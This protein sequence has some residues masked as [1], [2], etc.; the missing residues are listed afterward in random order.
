MPR[1]LPQR[2]VPEPIDPSTR[3][4]V[5]SLVHRLADEHP[6]ILEIKPSVTE[7]RT[8]DGLYVR[9]D[10]A[11]VNSIVRS[12]RT[13]DFEIA[14]AHPADH[15]LHVWLSDL[16]ARKVIE[17]RWG[18][19]FCLPMVQ[20]GWTMVYAPR[21]SKELEV[22]EHIVKASVQWATDAAV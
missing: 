9:K 2:Q 20:S 6:D 16:D 4:H 22:V 3:E 7:G 14:H 11:K 5:M 15:S 17:A 21:N 13:L 10:N 8:A 1:I 19:R 18:Q 12:D